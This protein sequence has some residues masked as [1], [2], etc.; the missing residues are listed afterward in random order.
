MS[1]ALW[2]PRNLISDHP[3]MSWTAISFG[4][5]LF[6]AGLLTRGFLAQR[7]S[8][9]IIVSPRIDLIKRLSEDELAKLPYPLDALPGARD[10]PS[11]YGCIRVYEWGPE[12]GRKVL[13]V[14]GISTPCLALGAVAHGLVEKGCR[15]MLFDLYELLS[16]TCLRTVCDIGN[17]A[18]LTVQLDSEEAIPITLQ[19]FLTT[20]A[21]SLPRFCLFLLHLLFRGQ[22]LP[23]VVSH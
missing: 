17:S 11:P 22:A 21:C 12:D 13:M 5:A 9:D 15:V 7:T 23:R 19:I 4:S 2:S 20:C 6:A 14:H 8:P 10:I 16:L 1:Y 3:W 18:S